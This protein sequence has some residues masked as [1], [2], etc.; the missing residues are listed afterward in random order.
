MHP[1]T[2]NRDEGPKNFPDDKRRHVSALLCAFCQDLEMLF[3]ILDDESSGQ[4]N[5]DRRV[6]CLAKILAGLRPMDPFE[7]RAV[8]VFARGARVHVCAP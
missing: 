7:T 3:Q 6:P 1:T 5:A 2:W 8:R 4:V